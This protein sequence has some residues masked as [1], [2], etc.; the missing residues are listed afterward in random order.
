M[1]WQS[2]FVAKLAKAG[3]T[4]AVQYFDDVRMQMEAKKWAQK[5]NGHKVKAT[6]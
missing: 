2:Q 1:P 6:W 5:F 4:S 3:S